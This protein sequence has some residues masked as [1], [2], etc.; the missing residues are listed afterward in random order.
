MSLVSSITRSK[1]LH[2]CVALTGR[3]TTGPPCS[4]GRRIVHAPGGRPA[5]PPAA[6]QITT[7]DDDDDRRQLAK[8]YWAIRRASNNEKRKDRYV[9]TSYNARG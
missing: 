5:R 1:G 7:D 8:Q 9:K 3:N 6:L 4:V 2:Q